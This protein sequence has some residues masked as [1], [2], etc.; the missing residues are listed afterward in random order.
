MNFVVPKVGRR[1]G[2]VAENQLSQRSIE[3]N[4]YSLILTPVDR[5]QHNLCSTQNNALPF[6]GRCICTDRAMHSSSALVRLG[7]G[8]VLGY[9]LLLAEGSPV[10]AEIRSEGKKGLF[11]KVNGKIDGSC[12]SG[13][14]KISG[15]VSAGKNLFYRFRKFD[16]RGKIKGVEFDSIGR[17]NV[18]VGVTSPKGSFIDKSIGLS[19]SASLFWLSPGGIHLSQ[20]ASFINVP[21]L[22]LSTA[23]T[24]RFGNGSF[25]VFRSHA[26]D[27]TGLSGQPLPGVLGFLVDP[28]SDLAEV[29][30][31]QGFT[32]MGL[33]C[34][35][36]NRS[37]SMLSMILTVRSSVISLDSPDNVGGFL[38]L[39][40]NLLM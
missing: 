29:S 18:I 15:G 22:N 26:S 39:A 1:T 35:S 31:V 12:G 33:M 40:G 4:Q 23:N 38:V 6:E 36:M 20:G 34:P 19:S 8:L 21:S 37:T 3:L 13:V 11:T 14:C 28:D 27:L 32:S 9:G 5:W 2:P 25:D 16:T 7:V 10:N 24:L 30:T 17:K